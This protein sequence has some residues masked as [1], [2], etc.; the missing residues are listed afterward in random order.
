MHISGIKLK[1][2]NNN[3]D[4]FLV[5]IDTLGISYYLLILIVYSFFLAPL[6][7]SGEGNYALS[8]I[9]EV[10]VTDDFLGLKLPTRKCQNDEKYE[11]CTTRKYLKKIQKHCNC[12]PY[13]LRNFTIPNQVILLLLTFSYHFC[14]L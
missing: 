5:Y 12:V 13:Q 3:R 7:L 9:K 1:H 4:K 8:V 14:H 10:E 2:V 11:D 6:I